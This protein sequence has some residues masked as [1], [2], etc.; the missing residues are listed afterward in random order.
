MCKNV[1]HVIYIYLM[2]LQ[3]FDRFYILDA[4]VLVDSKAVHRIYAVV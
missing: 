1:Y 4:S 3:Y 2:A